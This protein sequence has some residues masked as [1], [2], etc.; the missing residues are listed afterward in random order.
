MRLPKEHEMKSDLAS[1][2]GRPQ[3]PRPAGIFLSRATGLSA[4]A[5]IAFFGAGLA[6]A[7]ALPPDAPSL[8]IAQQ[9]A[10]YGAD[11][12]DHKLEAVLGRL[13][14]AWRER[15]HAPDPVRGGAEAIRRG[16]QGAEQAQAEEQAAR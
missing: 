11:H 2:R 12:P 15:A 13:R 6:R 4:A 1:Q 14:E 10:Q 7:D 16:I 5:L 8:E 9:A 3:S